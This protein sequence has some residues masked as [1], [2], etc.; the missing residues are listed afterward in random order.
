MLPNPYR[1]IKTSLLLE[2]SSIL[3]FLLNKTKIKPNFVTIFGIFFVYLG[4][5]FLS[6][7]NTS[8]IYYGLFIYFIKL[9]PD[10]V[11]GSLAY[12]KNLQSK[13]G[14]KLDLWAGEVNKIGVLCGFMLYIYNSTLNSQTIYL[15]L[16][17][18]LI[19]FIDPRKY[20]KDI[21][22]ITYDKKAK[23]H[24]SIEKKR[25]SNI[26]YSLL[27]FLNFDGRSGYCDFLIV[28]VLIDMFYQINTLLVIFPWIWTLLSIL[29]LAK[30]IIDILRR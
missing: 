26:I 21:S 14:H 8:L 30:S 4:T 17:I 20:L 29:V 1:K 13:N 3:L 24:L 5:F 27:R 15:L 22:K 11:D 2:I 25:T 28:L 9:V 12:L 6:S 16:I 18:I 23:S 7:N 19:N 10:Y